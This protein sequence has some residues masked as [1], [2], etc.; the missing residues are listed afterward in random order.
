MSTASTASDEEESD[1]WAELA[2]HRDTLQ[3]C[4]EE[5]VAFADDARTLLAKLEE[6]GYA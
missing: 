4:I 5:D 6:E 1:P 2:A 3:M